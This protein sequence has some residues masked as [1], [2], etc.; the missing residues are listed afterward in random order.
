MY[1]VYR[2]SSVLL[3]AALAL[4]A[5]EGARSEISGEAEGAGE[6]VQALSQ[7][8]WD[9]ASV[10]EGEWLECDHCRWRYCQCQWDGRW[11]NCTNQRPPEGGCDWTNPD[12]SDP[13]CGG[14]SKPCDR[15]DPTDWQNPSCQEGGGQSCSGSCHGPRSGPR[16]SSHNR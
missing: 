16:P 11:G 15:M 1:K 2:N 13:A 10:D 14:G 3:I 5:C 9:G 8:H 12:W 7:C 4:S 6:A